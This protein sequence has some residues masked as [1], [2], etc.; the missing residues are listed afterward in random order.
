MTFNLL[1]EIYIDTALL[2]TGLSSMN[3]ER[4][5]ILSRYTMEKA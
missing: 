3:Y 2:K 4:I 5:T 1:Y